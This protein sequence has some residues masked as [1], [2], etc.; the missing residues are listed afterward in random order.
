TPFA[1]VAFIIL[2][3]EPQESVWASASAFGSQTPESSLAE[4]HPARVIVA[5]SSPSFIVIAFMHGRIARRVPFTIA[6]ETGP[7][8]MTNLRRSTTNLRQCWPSSGS[9]GRAL[10]LC[11]GRGGGGVTFGSMRADAAGRIDG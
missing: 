8:V 6:R 4:L 3:F 11:D 5:N 9:G 1:L 7:F 2:P 10:A